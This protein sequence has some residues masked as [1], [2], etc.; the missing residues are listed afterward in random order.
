[1]SDLSTDI[2]SGDSPSKSYRV[3][4]IV[5]VTAAEFN[6]TTYSYFNGNNIIVIVSLD[7]TQ[8]GIKVKAGVRVQCFRGFTSQRKLW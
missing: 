6:S 5:A 1:M 3:Y 4:P 8:H 7:L 2:F